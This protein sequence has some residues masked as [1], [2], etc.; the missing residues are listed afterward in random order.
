MKQW[1]QEHQ[2][3]EIVKEMIN[4]YYRIIEFYVEQKKLDQVNIA[5]RE[6]Q[7]LMNT[8]YEMWFYLNLDFIAWEEDEVNIRII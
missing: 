2:E 6:L 4:K 7:N 8:F 3:Y 5:K 1:T